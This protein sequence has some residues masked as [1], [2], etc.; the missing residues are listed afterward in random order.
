M[1]EETKPISMLQQRLE[2]I[3][4]YNFIR[5][6]LKTYKDNVLIYDFIEI[7]ARY[8]NNIDGNVIK[9]LVQ[10]I[11]D[12][13]NM[14][15]KPSKIEQVVIYKKKGYSMRQIRD[16]TG[17]HPNTQ[18]KLL[19]DMQ[20]NSNL[21]PSIAPRLDDLTFGIVRDFMKEVNTFKEV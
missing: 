2:E 7:F 5:R 3:E 21:R 15:F 14:S 1:V 20:E 18:Y 9:S 19:E 4:F 12:K 17:L 16:I 8:N 13:N 10:N 11:R 6:L